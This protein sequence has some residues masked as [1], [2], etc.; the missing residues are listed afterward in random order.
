MS[1]DFYCRDKSEVLNSIYRAAK[2]SVDLFNRPISLFRQMKTAL[3]G[4]TLVRLAPPLLVTLRRMQRV[5]QV[6]G[7]AGQGRLL[8]CT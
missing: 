7:R 5:M 8:C 2:T 4:V 3:K 6:Q 1:W